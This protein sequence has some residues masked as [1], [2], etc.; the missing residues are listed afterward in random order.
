MFF[1]LLCTKFG[2]LCAIVYKQLM[3]RKRK[4]AG[5][6]HVLQTVT[7]CIST[8]MVLILLGLVVLTVFTGHNLSNYVKENLTVT[9][10][11]S[12]D[13]TEPEAR[14]LIGEVRQLPYIKGLTY[15]SK[16]QALR[17]GTK[18]LGADPREFAG[19]N[20]FTASIELQ[21]QP[22]YANND[23]ISWISKR[24]RNF[25]KVSDIDYK[26]DLV[27]QTNTTLGK[28]SVVLLVLAALL[29]IISFVL[30]NNTVRLNVYARRFTI[31]TMKLV[32]A[33]W[34]FIR[35]PF[36][37]DAF[38]LGL[39]SAIIAVAVLAGGVY[40]LWRDTPEIL[41]VIDWKVMVITA[42]AVLVFGL[43]IT[44]LCSLISVNRFLKASSSELYSI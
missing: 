10:I 39:A 29:A 4:H 37:R 12:Q 7:L 36:L 25:K 18:E 42:G 8:A 22:D 28:I 24:L 17:E 30:I 9:M 21:L 35:R 41:T 38:T 20:P 31:N 32:G 6:R 16:E 26:S 27:E 19:V 34:G 1:L 33:P 40:L 23:S 44:T 2:V 3:G 43:T 14:Q 11:L 15:I 13:M 5:S